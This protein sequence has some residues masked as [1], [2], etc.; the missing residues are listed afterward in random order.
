MYS[1]R[2]RRVSGSGGWRCMHWYVHYLCIEYSNK[3]NNLATVECSWLVLFEP[4]WSFGGEW[5]K[6]LAWD[7]TPYPLDWLMVALFSLGKKPS[8]SHWVSWVRPTAWC[9]LCIQN[10]IPPVSFLAQIT[11][12]IRYSLNLKAQALTPAA[13]NSFQQVLSVFEWWSEEGSLLITSCWCLSSHPQTSG[14]CP[15][16]CSDCQNEVSGL[17]GLEWKWF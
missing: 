14:G 4:T 15:S 10:G 16:H 8:R 7:L 3:W 9:W 2:K 6:N 1:V 17:H 5:I 11:G 13:P 12:N